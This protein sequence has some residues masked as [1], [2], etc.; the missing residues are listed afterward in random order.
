MSALVLFSI[1]EN[2]KI[3]KIKNPYS[4]SIIPLKRTDY[5]T[6][7]LTLGFVNVI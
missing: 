4:A 3:K 5:E 1:I 6:K 7:S 2:K